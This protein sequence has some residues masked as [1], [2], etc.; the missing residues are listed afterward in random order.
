MRDI[1]PRQ[2]L[3]SVLDRALCSPVVWIHGPGGSG[4]S[5][6]V[7][8]Y[9][10]SR[11]LPC[12]W[13]Q[14]DRGDDDISTFFY[15]LGVAIDAIA[16]GAGE[17]LPRLTPEY[18]Q[19]LELFSRRF[20]EKLCA[21]L[22][23]PSLLV[24][25]DCHEVSDNSPFYQVLRYGLRVLPREIHAICIGRNPPPAAMVHFRSRNLIDFIDWNDLRLTLEET[26]A[27]M[28]VRRNSRVATGHAH[29]FHER[30]QGWVAGLVLLLEARPQTLESRSKGLAPVKDVFDYFAAELFGGLDET[31]R[32]LLLGTAFLPEISPT[33]AQSLTGIDNAGRILAE[34]QEKNCFIERRYE[35][36][37]LYRYHP[38]FREFLIDSVIRR[39]TPEQVD[40]LR[41]RSA[42]LLKEAGRSE[43]AM[44]LLLDARCWNEATAL[45][46][47]SA[48]TFVAQGRSRTLLN[49]LAC[50]PDYRFESHPYLFF[51]RGSCSLGFD[52][53]Q[54]FSDFSKAFKGFEQQGDH[55]G[56]CLS[57]A[58]AADATLYNNFA[59]ME[60]IPIM[61]D[62]MRKYSSFPTPE[63]EA[64]VFA[65]LF[66]ATSLLQPDHARMREFEAKAY[67]SFCRPDRLEFPVRFET[68]MY[69]AVFNLWMGDITKASLILDTL[70]DLLRE[71]YVSDLLMI[72]LKTTRALAAFFMASFDHCHEAVLEAVRISEERF[73]PVWYFHVIAHGISAALSSGNMKRADTLIEKFRSRLADANGWDMGYFH[74]CLAWRARL[75]GNLDAARQNLEVIGTLLDQIYNFPS[76]A[77]VHV[78]F[79]EVLYQ[80]GYNE[81]AGE[82]LDVARH[83]SEKI[84]SRVVEQMILLLEADVEL[85][86][87]DQRKGDDLLRNAMELGAR[88]SLVNTFWWQPDMMVRLCTRALR[89][90]IQTEYTRGL[91]RLRGLTP[92][93]LSMEIEEWPW[94]VRVY[95][96]GRFE[97]HADNH[98]VCFSGKTQKKPLEMLKILI[99]LGG[100]EAWVGQVADLLWPESDGDIARNALKTTLFRLRELL[101]SEKIVVIREGKLTFDHYR[102]W[103]DAWVFENLL[104]DA[105][106]AEDAAG[107]ILGSALR[108]YRGHFLEQDREKLW[109]SALRA[110]LRYKFKCAITTMGKMLS[111]QGDYHGAA[112]WFMQ[113]V[114]VDELAEELYQLL[115]ECYLAA[116]L[117][118]EALS[119]FRRCQDALAYHG[120]TPSAATRA[121]HA[122]ALDE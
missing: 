88:H 16:P 94:A 95:T 96:L 114:E 73:V 68:G 46:E 80:L 44:E 116:D 11:L 3:F 60:W 56:M 39:L 108:L 78:S 32:L 9:A 86:H 66:N 117:R 67:D 75:Q 35:A 91:I 18:Q 90:G 115:M 84:G 64:R 79:A 27:I 103:V 110:R 6:L 23:Y 82:H 70:D 104:D 111:D 22:P 57:W 93:R 92:D 33:L 42:L 59:Y 109:S 43:H 65:S 77:V 52:P 40:Q 118:G 37:P 106:C 121:L 112:A 17:A 101:G 25:D 58:A 74:F 85:Q 24:I 19:Q 38:L 2:R 41:I 54:G 36:E 20:F 28:R 120:G 31:V 61:E 4:K 72:T 87:G 89:T 45:I 107:G 13:Y 119:V 69:L 7:A 8:S 63:L 5:S 100:S 62:Y 71:S 30:V 105:E 50:F 14:V 97:L 34:F 81:K 21:A 51:W 10:D 113:G 12:L 48:R 55:V 99:A 47:Q 53:H 1:V 49:W 122:R 83:I 76:H 98:C 26:E 102:I 29:A 15:Y